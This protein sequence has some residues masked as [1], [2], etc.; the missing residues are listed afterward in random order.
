MWDGGYGFVSMPASDL[1]D[2]VALSLFRCLL[3]PIGIFL[4]L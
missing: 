2:F 4:L 1:D 3:L